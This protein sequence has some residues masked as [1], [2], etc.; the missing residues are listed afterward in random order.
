MIGTTRA[1]DAQPQLSTAAT[2]LIHQAARP[3]AESIRWLLDEALE[4]TT[5]LARDRSVELTPWRH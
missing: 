1:A 5:S 4:R 2:E 3:Y